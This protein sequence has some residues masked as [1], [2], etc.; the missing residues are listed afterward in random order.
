MADQFLSAGGLPARYI[1][2]ARE[3]LARYEPRDPFA[4][5]ANPAA[6]LLL[7]Y[8]LHGEDRIVL[9]V[10]TDTVEH[11]KGQISFPGGAVHDEDGDLSVTALRETWEEVGVRPDAV[12]IIGRLD[13]MVTTSNF[14]VAPYAACCTACRT[15]TFR[16]SRGRRGRPSRRGRSSPRARR[17]EEREL[18]GQIRPRPRITG[19]AIGSGG[20]G[21]MPQ[22]CSILRATPSGSPP[23]ARTH[24]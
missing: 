7:L 4:P 13:G 10:R 8:H 21:A 18:Q 1:D 17:V 22:D 20:D 12:E 9:T 24:A 19:T 6:V 5:D 11:H 3:L 15:N 23:C 16:A 14:L 2:R